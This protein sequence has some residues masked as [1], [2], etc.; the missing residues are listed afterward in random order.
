MAENLSSRGVAG[1][2]LAGGAS[3]R[4]GRPKALMSFLGRPLA[5]IMLDLL[6]P[7]VERVYLNVREPTPPF[8]AL[9]ALLVADAAARRGAGPLA[10]VAAALAQ[11]QADGLT[12]LA[13]VP[14]DAPF[15]PL[16]LV[17]SLSAPL[18]A[19]APAAVAVSSFG[20]EPMFAL[21]PVTALA[22]VEAALA[23]GRASPRSVLEGLGAVEVA[24]PDEAFANLNTPAEFGAAEAA[25]NLLDALKLASAGRDGVFE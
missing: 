15:A 23:L 10:G 3:S 1:V 25:A 14:C 6:R 18:R 7:Q 5:L 16:D 17:A 19:G 2:V 21:W 11:A 13:T 20:L 22:R 24:F 9:G 8:V 12:L 4:M